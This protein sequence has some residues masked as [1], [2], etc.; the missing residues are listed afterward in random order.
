MKN[1]II[2]FFFTLLAYNVEAQFS[3]TIDVETPGTLASLLTET[4]KITITELTV[5][6]NIDARDIKC[7]RDD[8]SKL[9]KLDIS[10]VNIKTFTGSGGTYYYTTYPENELPIWSFFSNFVSMKSKVSLTTIIL[11]NSINSIGNSAFHDCTGLT[12]VIIPNSVTSIQFGAFSGCSSLTSLTLGNSLTFIGSAAFRECS[13]LPSLNLPSSLKSI[14]GS[15]FSYC[16][17]ITGNIII[18]NSV[19]TLGSS[20]FYRCSKLNSVTIGNSVK[21]IEDDVFRECNGLTN[22]IIP[23][24][25]T[26]MGNNVFYNC[27]GLTNITLG[28]SLTTIGSTCF[29]SCIKL[30]S[31]SIPNTVTSIGDD[32]F[33][34]CR[35]L[36]QLQLS[37]SLLKIG[38]NAF[39]ECWGLK[40]ISIP[41][42]VTSIGNYSF[43]DCR[44]ITEI[45]IP[46]SVTS[47]DHTAFYNCTSAT[48]LTI[49]SSV[50]Y[51]GSEAFGATKLANIYVYGANP[52]DIGSKYGVFPEAIKPT[53]ILHVPVGSLSAYQTALGWREFNNI[54][55]LTT[56]VQ[57][58]TIELVSISPNPVT[59]N[60]HFNG[61]K[62]ICTITLS[63]INGKTLFTK[64]V[65]ANENISVGTLTRGL[66]FISLYTKKGVIKYKLLKE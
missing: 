41:N 55:E 25:V 45:S 8:I 63:D 38:N 13:K 65:A 3:K 51:I 43:F 49:P 16:N 60:F 40:S 11:P 26:K 46:N 21:I 42:S 27:A 50:K 56:D 37:T 44:N 9:I 6:G 20:A 48:K 7:I 10:V 66:Y 5:K 17:N 34:G 36:T 35:A 62:E 2:I 64:A 39:R 29:R 61:L 4:E 19:D 58:T 47:I 57:S 30:E 15:A 54:S 24:S 53:C 59:N 33:W 14:S 28:N 1:I 32:A 31:I 18:G 22:V 12:G 52:I 23:N